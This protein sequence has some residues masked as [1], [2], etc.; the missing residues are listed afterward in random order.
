MFSHECFN[1]RILPAIRYLCIGYTT[2]TR[3]I[4]THISSATVVTPS[5]SR[6]VVYLTYTTWPQLKGPLPSNNS[7]YRKKSKTMPDFVAVKELV[8]QQVDSYRCSGASL[9]QALCIRCPLLQ[10]QAWSLS[11]VKHGSFLF[12]Y[13]LVQMKNTLNSVHALCLYV[14][15]L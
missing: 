4:C 6:S 15:F 3:R 5:H 7:L 1:P 9:V 2:P 8:E 12:A 14:I 11:N 10:L 13:F